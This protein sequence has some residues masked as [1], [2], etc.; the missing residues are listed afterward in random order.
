MCVRCSGDR[1]Q[2][3]WWRAIQRHFQ[4]RRQRIAMPFNLYSPCT[5]RHAIRWS[6]SKALSLTSADCWQINS[7]TMLDATF[8]RFM[9][10]NQLLCRRL[11]FSRFLLSP[12]GIECIACAL[13]L[14]VS[15][16]RLI[17]FT[18]FSLPFVFL[19]NWIVTFA[20]WFRWLQ[21]RARNE[22]RIN[23]GKN[24]GNCNS[25]LATRKKKT[26]L[27]IITLFN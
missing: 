8:L 9:I 24:T 6:Q 11:S 2:Q 12:L 21:G 19:F 26:Q 23:W 13:H 10:V 20:F 25:N 15:F 4:R 7:D 14:L 18:F 17:C 27:T 22:N 16:T 3:P 5:D 1:W